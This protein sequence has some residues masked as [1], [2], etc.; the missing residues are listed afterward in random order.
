MMK[1]NMI[2]TIGR[3]FGSGGREIGMGLSGALG[4]PF[5]DKELIV[6]AA[7]KS[8]LSEAMFEHVDEKAANSLLYSLVLGAYTPS[9]ALSGMPPVYMNETLFR[10]QSDVIC[11]LANEGPCVIVGRCADYI[12]RERDDCINLF[13][14]APLTHRIERVLDTCDV[15]KEKVED[16][17]A[18]T[19]KKRANFYNYYTG[20]KWG[21][22]K[23]YHISLDSSLLGVDGWVKALAQTL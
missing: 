7:K 10:I 18:K 19:D 11:D 17:I 4:I 5:Y 21:E 12:L 16:L 20:Q 6:A 8:G 9:N 22:A 15:T 1:K 3:Q 14:H 13:V 23:N 2:I